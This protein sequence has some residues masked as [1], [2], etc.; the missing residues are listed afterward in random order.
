KAT[1]KDPDERYQMASD[2]ADELQKVLDGKPVSAPPHRYKFDQ[3]EVAAER[4]GSVM[5]IG[6]SGFVIGVFAFVG[7][8][9][10]PIDSAADATRAATK[11]G[12]EIPT[13]APVTL[14]VLGISTMVAAQ[15]LL[16]GRKW[17]ATLLLL[18]PLCGLFLLFRS[19]SVEQM[20][21]L[22][23]GLPFRRG[24]WATAT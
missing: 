18:L 1:S 15:G 2:F 6:F 22:R 10:L 11:V 9:I 24:D 3:R 23:F 12:M 14:A 13:S 19:D 5:V 4:P 8:G 21:G 17:A 7:A 20:T 16:S